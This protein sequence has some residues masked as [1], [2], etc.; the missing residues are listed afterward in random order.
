MFNKAVQQGRGMHS[1]ERT[2]RYV[3]SP[4]AARTSL[5]DFSASCQIF[6]LSPFMFV[7]EMSHGSR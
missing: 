3:D 7:V 4:S 6:S 2:L 1:G 5:V